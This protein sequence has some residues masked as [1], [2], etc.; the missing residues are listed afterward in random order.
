M[1]EK[2]FFLCL[3]LLI[4]MILS[5][6]AISAADT[7]L[8]EEGTN[9]IVSADRVIQDTDAAY[10]SDAI[11][12]NYNI[13]DTNLS[14][15][16]LSDE[17][18]I[19]D[20][21]LSESPLSDEDSKTTP[22]SSNQL[23]DD[24]DHVIYVSPYGPDDADGSMLKSYN[25][26]KKALDAMTEDGHYTIVLRAGNYTGYNNTALKINRDNL[27]I[28]AYNH[29]RVIVDFNIASYNSYVGWNITGSNIEI[30]GI[31]FNRTASYARFMLINKTENISISDCSFRNCTG[32]LDPLIN[33]MDSNN[34]VFENNTF[35]SV[36]SGTSSFIIG[37]VG[38]NIEISGNE[39]SN[40]ESS[41]LRMLNSNGNITDNEFKNFT[42]YYGIYSLSS[43]S[44]IENNVFENRNGTSSD[45]Y[46]S[47]YLQSSESNISGNTFKNINL[48]YSGNEHSPIYVYSN[49]VANISDNDFINTYAYYGGAIENPSANTIVENN[50]FTNTS[51]YYGGAI[52][53][54][55]TNLTLKNNTV[56]DS[57][58]SYGNYVNNNGGSINT[59][60]ITFLN[61]ETITTDSFSVAIPVLVT[62]DVG[63]QIYGKT[64][65]VKLNESNA[66]SITLVDGDLSLTVSNPGAGTYLVNGNYSGALNAN[67]KTGVI[68]FLD[69]YAGPFYVATNG[70]DNNK[71]DEDH[72]F[73]SIS[74]AIK[75]ASMTNNTHA[76]FI[77]E[78]TYYENNLTVSSALNIT[79]LGDVCID[80]YNA[81]RA[82]YVTGDN[83][84]ISNI[85]VRNTNYTYSGTAYGGAVYWGGAKG[86]LN[87]ASFENNLAYS[88]SSS[89]YGGAVY[90]T[91]ANGTINNTKFK[92][93]TAISYQDYS[94][95]GAVY[96]GGLNG[97]V[98]NSSF[99]DNEAI[100]Y[101][102]SFNRYGGAVY[103]NGANGK[104][105]NSEFDNNTAY[106]GGT[107]SNYAVNLTLSNNSI[108][109]SNGNSG[110]YIYSAFSYSSING[111]VVTILNN[112]TV[113]T[114][115]PYVSALITVTDDMGNPI[116]GGSVNVTVNG[117]NVISSADIYENLTVNI[118]SPGVGEYL[119]VPKYY[120]N[121]VSPASN[122]N[123]T[124]RTSVIKWISEPYYGPFYVA[125]N[126]SDSNNGDEDHPFASI[127]AALKAVNL[128][129]A[130]PA[131]FI[132]EGNYKESNLNITKAVNITGIGEV[133]I[134]A[135][136]NN[137]IFN[138]SA[139]YVNITNLEFA[140]GN[141]STDG[142]AI[143][144]SGSYGKLENSTFVNNT[145]A[146]RGG[147]IYN[148]GNYLKLSG[149]NISDSN[150]SLGRNIYNIGSIN[151]TTLRLMH[152]DTVVLEEGITAYDLS[153]ELLDDM[154]N[155]IAGG[156]VNVTLNHY[157]ATL[158]QNLT[159]DL[160]IKVF[161]PAYGE[162]FV[163]GSY[164]SLTININPDR[165]NYTVETGSLTFLSEPYF[166]PFY[167]ATNGSDYYDG[168]KE[169]PFASI[170]QAIEAASQ[171]DV[172]PAIYINEGTYNESNLNVTKAMN[173][174][175]LG[176][177]II[178]AKG[179]SYV[180]DVRADNV[181]ISNI[182]LAN[183]N[184]N[185]TGAA[186]TWTGTNGTL[187]NASFINNSANDA[188]ALYWTG[189][190]GTLANSTF[191]NN[192]ASNRGGA[193]IYVGNLNHTNNTFINNSAVNEGGAI[194]TNKTGFVEMANSTFI[195]NS[196]RLG[197]A[198]F[199]DYND[200]FAPELYNNTEFNIYD[201]QF[202]N[203][204]AQDG[205]AVVLYASNST[206]ANSTFIANNA[207][208][209]GDGAIS[210]GG[211]N[212]TIINNTFINNT[213]FLYAG[214]IGSN[215]SQIINNTFINNS[216]YQAGAI[217]TINDTII[218][219]TFE[220]NNASIGKSIVYL[221]NYNLTN[222]TCNCSLDAYECCDE[223]CSCSLEEFNGSCNCTNHT[224][225]ERYSVLINNT[226]DDGEVFIYHG[227][228]IMNVSLNYNGHYILSLAG[229]D[230]LGADGYCIEFNN[231]MPWEMNGTTGIAIDSTS[232][233]RNSLDGS[234]VGDYV[235]VAIL[236]KESFQRW[237]IKELIFTFTDEDYLNS[238]D[239]DIQYIIDIVNDPNTI[240]R[241]GDNWINGEWYCGDIYTVIHPT[242]RQNLIII[243]G[244]GEIDL[245]HLTP[246]KEA[247]VTTV[248]D[249][250]YVNYTISVTN[251]EEIYLH[252][253][254]V[255]DIPDSLLTFI[256]WNNTIKADGSP[257]DWIKDEDGLIWYL[258]RTLL[259]GETVTFYAIFRA[260]VPPLYSQDNS[261][262]PIHNKINVT[263]YETN[264]DADEEIIHG[265]SPYLVIRKDTLDTNVSVGDPVRFLITITNIGEAAA[266][267][268]RVNDVS[269][270]SYGLDYMSWTNGFDNHTWSYGPSSYNW[271]LNEPLLP[272]E[273]A[274]FIVIFNAT[275]SGNMFANTALVYN[276]NGPTNNATNW[277]NVSYVYL[278]AA[279][280]VIRIEG[281][282]ITFAL[283]V[284][285]VGS[286]TAYGAYISESNSYVMPLVNWT[287]A[288]G[289][290]YNSHWYYNGPNA[291][292][293]FSSATWTLQDPLGPGG[294]ATIL[295][296]LN[297]TFAS[298]YSNSIKVGDRDGQKNGTGAGGPLNRYLGAYKTVLSVKDDIIQF[299][300]TV[301]N[302]GN[303]TAHN[304]T[305]YDRLYNYGENHTITFI[306]WTDSRGPS[307]NSDW[308]SNFGS[309][310][311]YFFY[312]F[313]LQQAL[314]P[315]GSASIVL[316]FNTTNASGYS[317]SLYVN[318]TNGYGNGTGLGSGLTRY[319]GAYKTVL[320]VKDDI[321]Q[322]M[323]TVTNQGNI[324][325]HNVT[326]YDRLYNY[327]ENHTIT[328]INWTDSRGPSHNSDWISNF[329]S[330]KTYFFYNFTLQQAL[331][332][333]GSA[334]IV[335]TFNTSNASGY[336]NSLSV[337]ETNGFGNGTGLGGG[338]NRYV[339]AYKTVLEQSGDTIS[340]LLTVTNQGN[341][342]ANGF[343]LTDSLFRGI[344]NGNLCNL[345][346]INWTDYRGSQFKS[347]W[348]FKGFTN[349]GNYTYY[350][351]TYT[352]Q[353]RPG[354]SASI[355][356]TFNTSN[357][358]GYSNG[359]SVS[360]IYGGNGT[361]ITG[362]I[363][364]YIGAYKTVVDIRADIITFALTVT[365]NGNTSLD[366]VYIYDNPSSPYMNLVNWSDARGLSYNSD[367][368]YYGPYAG[369][370]FSS[371][372]WRL[373]Y[374]LA[375]GAARTIFLTLNTST[376]GGYSNGISVSAYGA[377]N[378]TGLGDSLPRYLGA[379][380]TVLDISEDTITFML[381]VTN[382]G[383][384]SAHG[385]YITDT[386]SGSNMALVNWTDSRGPDMNS[387]WYYS[388]PSIGSSF[389]NARWTLQ[390]PLGPGGSASIILVLN[391]T[392]AAG[393]SN[394]ISVG[395]Q[396]GY[397]NGT[398]V[399]GPIY[400]YLGAYKVALDNNT[401]PDE[402]MRFKLT[403]S[404][405]GNT[406]ADLVYISD[407]FAAPHALVSWNDSRG[408]Q[409]NSDW[410]YD[411]DNS[412]WTYQ[413][414][415]A[416]GAS[417]SIDVA[418]NVTAA[419]NYSNTL[420][421][422]DR[423][424]SR[425]ETTVY[426]TVNGIK[427]EKIL[428][429][430][431]TVI[432]GD[433]AEYTVRVTNVLDKAIGNV[434]VTD[435][436]P[437]GLEY[438]DYIN[439][440]GE[441]IL[442][443]DGS[444]TLVGDLGP[445]NYSEIVIRF[446]TTESGN[447]TNVVVV[448]SNE[449]ENYTGSNSTEVI[450]PLTVQKITLN[451][452]V[453]LSQKTGFAIVVKNIGNINLTNVFVLEESFEGLTNLTFVPSSDNWF[454]NG[455]D[456]WIYDGVLEP[457]QSVN[458][459][460]VFD[461]T[462][463]G[464]FNNTVVA[465]SSETSNVTATN[466]TT[467][468]KPDVIIQK[469]TLNETVRAGNLTEFLIFVS[470]EG[471]SNLTNF[472]VLDTY[473]S[474]LVY[475]N[476]TNRTG[477][478]ILDDSEGLKFIYDG[479]LK[480][481]DT[482]SFIVAFNTTEVGNFTN[483]VSATADEFGDFVNSSNTTEVIITELEIIKIAN[484]DTVYKGETI[485]FTI[486]VTNTGSVDLTH[487]FIDDQTPEGAEYLDYEN[488]TGNWFIC[489]NKWIY[490]GVLAPGETVQLTIF[491][492]TT[493]GGIVNNTAIAGS[494]QSENK[495]ANNTTE[496]LYNPALAVEKVTLNETVHKGELT[497][498]NITLY[499]TGDATLSEVYIRE[500]VPDGLVYVGFVDQSNMWY[501]NEG[502]YIYNGTLAVGESTVFTVIFNTTRVGNFTNVVVANSKETDEDVQAENDTEVVFNPAL[503]V[504]KIALN[505]TVHKGQLT[506]FT[507]VVSNI[508][509]EDLTDVYVVDTYPSELVYD[510]FEDE[511]GIWY[512][513]DGKWIYNGT[514]AV[515]DSSKFTV[516]FN[517]TETGSFINEV[518][519][520]SNETE[521][522]SAQNTTTVIFNPALEVIKV[523]LN[524]TVHK[525]EL[526][527]FNITVIN[528]GEEDL[529][530]VSVRE[531]IPDGLVYVGFVDQSNMWY[532]NEGVYIYNGTLAVGESTVFTVIFNT[533]RVGNFTNVVV[534]NSKETD[535]DVQAEN[536]T[537]V[538]FNPGMSIEKIA[539]NE[540]VYVGEI[541]SYTIIVTNTGEEDLTHV[542]IDDLTPEGLEYL[543]YENTSGNW[544]ICKEKWVFDGVLAPGE[545][546]ELTIFFNTTQP[547]QI[548]NT[549][550]GGS[551]D[552]P[553]STADNNTT[554]VYKPELS[555]EKLTEN[556]VVYNGETVEFTIVVSNIGDCEIDSPF[557]VE[558]IPE[559]L[560]FLSYVD[561][562][563]KWTF[564][565]E[566][567]TWTYN[568]IL[569]A[570]E[571]ARFTIIFN[572]TESGEFT[573]IV[574]AGSN[575]TENVTANNT[576]NVF[577][578]SIEIEKLANDEFVYNGNTTSYVIKVVNTGDC[579]VN[580]VKVTENIPEGIIYLGYENKTGSWTFDETSYTWTLDA[581]L[582][583][584]ESAEILVIFNTTQSGLINNTIVAESNETV[585]VTVYNDTTIV[586]TPDVSV[587]KVALNET[588]NKGQLAQFMIIVTNTGDCD[589]TKVFVEDSWPEG[590]IAVG[591]IDETDKWFN[592]GAHW[593]YDGVLKAGE[594]ANFTVVF[595]TNVSGEFTNI[596][597]AG[598]NIT[599]N[600]SDNDTVKVLNPS[601]EI[602]KTANDD[603]VYVGN[604]TSYTITITNTGDTNLTDIIIN[605]FAPD[606]LIY[607]DYINKTGKWIYDG[608]L[609]PG[610]TAQFIVIYN[611]TASGR[612]N[613]KILVESGE[614]PNSTTYNNTTVV[615][616]PSLNVEK[617]TLNETVFNGN[618]SE[619]TIVV[620]NTG[621]CDLTEVFVQEEIPDGLIYLDFVD[622]SGKWSYDADSNRFTYDGSLAV[623]ESSEFVVVFNTT[624][625]GEFVNT[626]TAGSNITGNKTA[627][628]KTNVFTPS[629]TVEKIA[630]NKT[631]YAGEKTEF[632]II[633]KNNGDC[634]LTNIVVDEVIPEGL[635]YYSFVDET[636]KWANEGTTWTYPSLAAGESAS[637][638]VIFD[639]EEA[640]NF[641]NTVT[642][643]S[644]QTGEANATNMTEVIDKSVPENNTDENDIDDTDDT[645]VSEDSNNHAKVSEKL[646]GLASIKAGNPIMVL[647][648]VLAILGICPIYRK[649]E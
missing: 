55:G 143:Y 350:N 546:A 503:E 480:V 318:E 10:G 284:S 488:T 458:F 607:I 582:G 506:G 264:W 297:T 170:E 387:H 571:S 541:V 79:G 197:G 349:S 306:N 351:W 362:N 548:N 487:V 558:N 345:K 365:N 61:N 594:S 126:G 237:N 95:G 477:S 219:N 552:T 194:F 443:E 648:L 612:I 151:G 74:Q 15:S 158:M 28:K 259:P 136:G 563:N 154:N 575:I 516:W 344:T 590:L 339:G 148:S 50:R 572:T 274:S 275:H 576:T 31:A 115:M 208:R 626:V 202:I 260:S 150:A 618:T 447:I 464:V 401:L 266:Y 534:A 467:V 17:N 119:F 494:D 424:G 317:N 103:W 203:N 556:T 87:N 321:I 9:D 605:E 472:Y 429:N 135:Q 227:S 35:A 431:Q 325:A 234:Y 6:S 629:L 474:E 360:T 495:T 131:I 97:T 11:E 462:Q 86:T 38:S 186:M 455:I 442:N 123:Y 142:G 206:I 73:A 449:T 288:R 636:G 463:E 224:V 529:T 181:N 549:V 645:P 417:V 157:N 133:I 278:N 560:V 146:D 93:N 1:R 515:G 440:T 519:A 599:G 433:I 573:N 334:S 326:L 562:D 211:E 164:R 24:T 27:T 159:D 307:H 517:T 459:T 585:N 201:S 286:S 578:P 635:S 163:N 505:E 392:Y 568:G 457:G 364:R 137:G 355:V 456:K 120:H 525:G 508:G 450:N 169:H 82:L 207:T 282:L 314:G 33:I 641:T 533:T 382:Q 195:N 348:I 596:A 554:V 329:G 287:D 85:N 395:E 591:F 475:Y 37:A 492:N 374:P 441:W 319:L 190:N 5:V 141:S 580:G 638:T 470:N 587:V 292:S 231:S 285:N 385:T 366:N 122:D 212:N 398:G 606:D 2:R 388:G 235:K 406:T 127:E 569:E 106:Y 273:S 363:T 139:N 446:N 602:N 3:S 78:G 416:P 313:T 72:P 526:T 217:L 125:A 108:N 199:V 538:I 391:T 300:I 44:T 336:S 513:N 70:S 577:T 507:I 544:F 489:K 479:I 52:Y 128:T 322:F 543:S 486:N 597:I 246:E 358:T 13:K 210:S 642:A 353:L 473:P 511:N 49:S 604:T 232:F 476:Y 564:D 178:D 304:V 8:T 64:V 192:T 510:S 63:N 40:S 147:S 497:E 553:N 531:I 110:K 437:A 565:E 265:V 397:G 162:Y 376:A 411:E 198:I 644:D 454:F 89:A 600:V 614:T 482:A 545:S 436:V 245:P 218:N 209:Y 180:L 611:T 242:T 647:L 372:T 396:N 354:A 138:I 609:Q 359:M 132:K 302:Q 481:G 407:N 166:G 383:N 500:Q 478:W 118:A 92:N 263:S 145:A 107:I 465:G 144:W 342:T 316:T 393:Y 617:I 586:Y 109:N 341:I 646:T 308:I 535:E 523:T 66:G 69:P 222:I 309:N 223:N 291:G 633:V 649:R 561:E 172:V 134:D 394:G 592:N 598:S 570:G 624:K 539:N 386:L 228:P 460:V 333:G 25:T 384:I 628:N 312:N 116:Y 167:V 187:T 498:F 522:A 252:N 502:V 340:F 47:I 445:N 509:E 12:E 261:T 390:D 610:E 330:N 551:D 7:N 279:K 603:I 331:G 96:W 593:I 423:F 613:N 283:T 357:A 328:F 215:S 176:D 83:V 80:A 413:K 499:N 567:F 269:W 36:N 77:K 188:G 368:T 537:E 175:G 621:D 48:T 124:A 524:E 111:A 619:F 42:G 102:S 193:L 53:N 117:T 18:N 101:S 153:V 254:T 41:I 196:A 91:G 233:I 425:N 491:Y 240:L 121:Y 105:T 555:V 250:D 439:K 332:P 214:A 4:L 54:T 226:L 389:G 419:G 90:W 542:F 371:G 290:D 160:L 161:S 520:Y 335:L 414:V 174:T 19:K 557:V 149:N 430:N 32:G 490:D 98:D 155:S 191:I 514:L 583:I 204:S 337:N 643:K 550:I 559:G 434:T 165:N 71:G 255:K 229:A 183:A 623:N 29:A 171:N 622:E 471:N 43:N 518:S 21:N 412:K 129:N 99:E 574:V 432:L 501:E 540:S 168:S 140:N 521:E 26:I 448:S 293:N 257:E 640:G 310:K 338:L 615:Y 221:Q 271:Y 422:G 100:T 281:E 532:E 213:A 239:P 639:T 267:N 418:Y 88:S 305:L 30:Q 14:V 249:G 216:A 528:I 420:I 60:N 262:L 247:N 225:V 272:H 179:S 466:S 296:T 220:G 67:V 527:E 410:T 68:E 327:G 294:S 373:N 56:K 39:F 415:L 504:I 426:V 315:G 280:N 377:G 230:E 75:A 253:V 241:N 156:F 444:W 493:E 320:S 104:L 268:A 405:Y 299:M 512:Y 589:L 20:T 51:A 402:L 58:A 620:S 380:K 356:I 236:L 258:N 277:T 452:T 630:L 251:D 536:I 637:F 256:G 404:N 243:N 303:I 616:S 631:V 632:T 130:V 399:G 112:S 113:E 381:T 65:N 581:P 595:Y 94:Y 182:G 468:L 608:T 584:G 347:D 566:T 408:F 81:G 301:T 46:S 152:N 62:D 238:Q 634:E 23:K 173:I 295:L 189:S 485:S 343:N 453:L 588:V 461:T 34:V 298:S 496:V 311:T 57:K 451:E 244:C 352:K 276:P 438:I 346:Y 547:G 625:S 114:S 22:K 369:N 184:K 248:Q 579:D 370:T 400:R 177:V 379:Y 16:P 323:I 421:V 45:M 435:I 428:N 59:L 403:V 484:N 200:K 483:N 361:G 375:P 409:F 324:T 530:E 76:V 367:W 469:I 627:N 427:V 601:V 378:G 289:I 205:G 84:N 185:G 270:S